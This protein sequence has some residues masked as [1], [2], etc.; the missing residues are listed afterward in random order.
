MDKLNTSN[1][2]AT[3]EITTLRAANRTLQ[4]QVDNER[5]DHD[6]IVS[7]LQSSLTDWDQK[8]REHQTNKDHY[9]DGII[10]RDRPPSYCT[11]QYGLYVRMYVCDAW[12]NIHSVTRSS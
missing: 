12:L 11:I 8:W 6:S 1:R 5:R 7:S 10:S 2:V 3:N 9:D 4:Q